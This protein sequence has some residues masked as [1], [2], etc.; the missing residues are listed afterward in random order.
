MYTGVRDPLGG[1]ETNVIVVSPSL[2]SCVKHRGSGRWTD[3][4]NLKSDG[5]VK[6]VRRGW[7][8]SLLPRK[9]ESKFNGKCKGSDQGL[10]KRT[11][12]N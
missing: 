2:R 9:V 7:E 5:K 8:L 4:V 6:R 3:E 1:L 12:E 11:D 10:D